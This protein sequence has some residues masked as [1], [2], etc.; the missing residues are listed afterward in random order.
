[1]LFYDPS[2]NSYKFTRALK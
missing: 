1:M 2:R